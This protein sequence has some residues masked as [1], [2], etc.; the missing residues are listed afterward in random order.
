MLQGIQ[1]NAHERGVSDAKDVT[2]LEIRHPSEGNDPSP[3]GDK[4]LLP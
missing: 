2:R 3:R 1:R 4:V